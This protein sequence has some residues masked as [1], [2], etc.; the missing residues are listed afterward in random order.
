M[1]ATLCYICNAPVEPYSCSKR[2]CTQ[3]LGLNKKK[4]ARYGYCAYCGAFARLSKDHVVPKV[5]GGSR[6]PENIEYVCGRC[7]ESKGCML[8]ADWLATLPSSY[9]QHRFVRQLFE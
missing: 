5:L 2:R 3:C 4:S 9:P 6:G 7:N 1:A 8:M